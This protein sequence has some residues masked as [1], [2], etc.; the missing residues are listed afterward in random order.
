MVAVVEEDGANDGNDA[1]EDCVGSDE[2]VGF[3]VG[4]WKK[5]EEGGDEV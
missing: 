2:E 4:C 1:K 3:D 5:G